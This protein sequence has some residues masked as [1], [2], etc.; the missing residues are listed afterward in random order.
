MIKHPAEI[1][2]YYF[3]DRSE[4][5][6]ISRDQHWCPFANDQCNKQ[7]RLI[8]FPMGVCSIKYGNEIIAVC[9][10]R[11][12]QNR[13]IFRNI[14][15]HY[16]NTVDNILL[17]AEVGLKR[18]GN[19]DFILVKH[20][21]L[22]CDVEDFVIVEFQ[23]GQTTSTGKLV[24][25]YTDYLAGK[26]IRNTSYNFGMNLAD[27]WKRTFT[28]ILNKG[29]VLEHWGNK[30]YWVVQEPVYQNFLNRYNLN[31]MGFNEKYNTVFFIYDIETVGNNCSLVSTR[32]ESSSTDELFNAFRKNPDCQASITSEE[33]ILNCR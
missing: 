32:I 18:V 16:F 29:I 22:S 8:D 23:T 24:E 27:I 13:I 25:A 26:D 4:R 1:F 6:K 15:E 30:A 5:A 9:P 19:F 10:R 2:G 31:G 20:K 12:L 33:I 28:Q 21:P 7:S 17:F 14:A 11:F 3:E